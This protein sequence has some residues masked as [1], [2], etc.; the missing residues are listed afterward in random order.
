LSDVRRAIDYYE[1]AIAIWQEIGDINGFAIDSFNMAL[2]YFEQNDPTRALPL[3]QEAAQIWARI[4]NP[5]VHRAQ[6]LVT[7]LHDKQS[8]FFDRLR[9]KK[10]KR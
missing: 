6:Q 4:G 2:L 5:N 8:G 1:Q 3:A 7:R 10:D 9:G